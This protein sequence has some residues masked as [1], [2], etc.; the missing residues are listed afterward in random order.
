MVHLMFTSIF[1]LEVTHGEIKFDTF[2]KTKMLKWLD[3]NKEYLEQAENQKLIKL[4]NKFYMDEMI[5]NAVR[6]KRPVSKAN[7]QSNEKNYSFSVIE[8][9]RKDCDFCNSAYKKNTANDIFERLESELSYSA[10][11]AFKY[12]K[13]HSLIVSR[14]HNSLN[15]TEK[16]ITDMFEVGLKWFQK[17]NNLDSNANY[18]QMEWD[19]MPKSGASQIHSHFH[20][21]MS[22]KSYYGQMR[23][24]QHASNEYF[25]LTHRDF[26]DDFILVHKALGLVYELDNSYV[27]VNLVPIKDQEVMIVGKSY[28]NSY[29]SV[30]KLFHQVT[31]IFI[32]KF[33]QYSFSAAMY[34]PKFESSDL[35]YDPERLTK[36]SARLLFRSSSNLVRSDFNGLDLYTSSVIGL[37]RYKLASKLFEELKNFK[38]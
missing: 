9:S 16:E 35:E 18:P 12:D 28:P 29:A 10:A 22:L 20:V 4:Y 21:S 34:L 23:R 37:D 15:L 7:G 31:R 8:E 38:N 32:D 26:F 30:V 19:A 33:D 36:I 13:W 24:W 11:N 5:Y 25:S 17:V 14:N 6:G 27:I 2:F 1:D 3:N